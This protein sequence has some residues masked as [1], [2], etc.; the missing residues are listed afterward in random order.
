MFSTTNVREGLTP[1]LC[2][3]SIGENALHSDNVSICRSNPHLNETLDV[4]SQDAAWREF[5]KTKAC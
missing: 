5:I 3:I 4:I 2:T 1:A